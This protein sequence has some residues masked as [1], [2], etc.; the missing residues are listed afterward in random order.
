MKILIAS[1]SYKHLTNGVSNAVVSLTTELKKRGHEVKVIAMSDKAK[2]YKDGDDYYFSSVKIPIYP[3][4]RV[5]L[6]TNEK[7]LNEILDWEPEIA[8]IHTEFSAK[9]L[10]MMIVKKLNIPFVV[11]Y[12]TDYEE[13]LHSL[14]VVNFPYGKPVKLWLKQQF[15]NAKY[16]IVP[17]AKVET[18]LK[19]Y[20]IKNPIKIIPNG[21]DL[22]K[23]QKRLDPQ[24]K[25]KLLS[26]LGLKNNG[27]ILSIV[28]R[29]SK[30][31]NIDEIIEFMPAL[32]KRDPEIKLVIAGDG[33]HMK[34]LKKSVAELGLEKS[35]V[36]V[37]M[38]PSSEVYKYYQLGDL[39]VCASTFETQGLTYVEAMASGLPLVCR[40]DP[41]LV[42]IIDEG[43]NGYC[44]D[45]VEDYTEHVL[46][47]LSDPE[48]Q[49]TMA[50]YS[51]EK[52]NNFGKEI[53]IDDII[54]T[55]EYIVADSKKLKEEQEAG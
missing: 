13:F 45:G 42:T 48:K 33:P 53:L 1:D 21:I 25:E 49:R 11:T 31:K 4:A 47:I 15:K 44:Y 7:L 51:F 12:H 26:E 30:E 52:S 41:C 36:F 10:A 23:Y 28:S 22:P 50:Q 37:G 54:D 17:S 29:I 2:S 32:L 35:V 39:F 40:R 8:H 43:K 46:E 34:Q 24:E 27:K 20:D 16:V 9:H 18:Q 6:S 19:G 55:Y 38:V 14:F 5:S 3:D